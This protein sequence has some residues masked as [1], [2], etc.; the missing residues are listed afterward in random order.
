MAVPPSAPAA[1]RSLCLSAHGGPQRR[2]ALLQC[3]SAATGVRVPALTPEDAAVLLDA[4]SH[5]A[6]ERQPQ[7]AKAVAEALA[8]LAAK[9]LEAEAPHAVLADN[10]DGGGARGGNARAAFHLRL[11]SLVLTHEPPPSTRAAWLADALRAPGGGPIL[12]NALACLSRPTQPSVPDHATA[13]HGALRAM[14][15]ALDLAPPPAVADA[16]T[17]LLFGA[18]GR[19]IDT[20]VVQSAH[21]PSVFVP[22]R[23]STRAFLATLSAL[24]ACR[25]APLDAKRFIVADALARIAR[26]EPAPPEGEASELLGELVG[27]FIAAV[28]TPLFAECLEHA[29]ACVTAVAH[30]A[31]A[32]YPLLL[33]RCSH[34]VTVASDIQG[35]PE[36]KLPF[37]RWY[38]CAARATRAPRGSAGALAAL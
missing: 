13:A 28:P 19:W 8:A 1:L 12:A 10:A 33:Q 38:D 25:A 34:V 16:A 11:W 2:Q 32:T 9:L 23:E 31:P 17:V 20:H 30:R 21:G 24:L 26:A 14:T 37:A 7:D 5:V 29:L 35:A 18:V 22:H 27:A 6:S 4:M 3:A 15:H 36:R